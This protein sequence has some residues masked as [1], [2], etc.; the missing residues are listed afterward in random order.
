MDG[1]CDKSDVL[2]TVKDRNIP[3][4]IKRL[5]AACIA[6]ILR[7]NCLPTQVLGGKIEGRIDV[8]VRRWRRRKQLLDDLQETIGYWTLKERK[9]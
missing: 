8:K 5:E 1:P 2:H 3:H 7:R 6:H 4:A 9:H